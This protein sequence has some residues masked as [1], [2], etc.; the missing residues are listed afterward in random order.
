[1]NTLGLAVTVLLALF[2][3]LLLLSLVRFWFRSISVNSVIR[4]GNTNAFGSSG[5]KKERP[6][7]ERSES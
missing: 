1:M 2:F 3:G 7:S 5:F 6:I 4:S